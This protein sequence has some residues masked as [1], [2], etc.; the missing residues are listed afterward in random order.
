[1]AVRSSVSSRPGN[2]NPSST[3]CL[4]CLRANVEAG[5]FYRGGGW[6]E[7]ASG[8]GDD[9]PFAVLEKR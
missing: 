9:G 1:M 7:V 8:E 4:K 6:K 2:P 3:T 5:A